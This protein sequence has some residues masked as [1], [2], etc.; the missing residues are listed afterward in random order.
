MFYSH[1]S[2]DDLIKLFYEELDKVAKWLQ[3]NKPSRNVTKTH[4]IVSHNR[5][6]L[7]DAEIH[8][9]SNNS[10]IDQV[11]SAKFPGIIINENLT[12]SDHINVILNKTN[13]N[14][15]VIRRLAKSLLKDVLTTFY[16]KLIGMFTILQYCMRN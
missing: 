1:K 2:L 3:I 15:R 16:V 10:L 7:I 4:C 9:K 11:G 5:Q 13:N 14:F 12:W 6:T 8:I